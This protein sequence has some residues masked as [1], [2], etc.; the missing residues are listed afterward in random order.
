MH[1]IILAMYTYIYIF[2]ILTCMHKYILAIRLRYNTITSLKTEAGSQYD[3]CIARTCTCTPMSL[4]NAKCSFS[5]SDA[6]T[7]RKDRIL[8]V[9]VYVVYHVRCDEC[10]YEGDAM[11][12]KPLCH[13]ESSLK[14]Y[15]TCGMQTHEWEY[16]RAGLCMYTQFFKLTSKR[17]INNWTIMLS[18]T[19][20]G[21]PKTHDC[22][23]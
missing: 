13:S 6:R 10:Q 9:H 14:H 20:S 17:N 22:D 2:N 8:H 16:T 23:P 19:L 18:Y 11:Q 5:W 21:Q 7:P 4:W 15:H 1:T 12:S 3:P